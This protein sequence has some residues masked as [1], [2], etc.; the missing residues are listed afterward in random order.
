MSWTGYKPNGEVFLYECI[1]APVVIS[2]DCV[3]TLQN[4]YSITGTDG[5]GSM[6][7]LVHTG[8]LTAT[9][10]CEY[11]NPCSIW[12]TVKT[13][14]L[15]G[16]AGSQ[17]EFAFPPSACPAP[18]GPT[19]AGSGDEAANRAMFKWE[20][21]E[22]VAPASISVDY[23]Q[24][25]SPLG[26]QNFV[27][28]LV[29]Y[30]VTGDP[31]DQTQLDSLTSQG[32]TFAYAPLSAS[33]LVF[34][35]NVHD[36]ADL[37]QVTDMKLTPDLL[38]KIFTR[39]LYN[40]NIDPNLISLNP[41]APNWAPLVEPVGEA[42]ASAQTFELTSWFWA[43]AQ[44]TYEAGGTQF[45]GG[46]TD[47]YPATVGL[48]L[49]QT[50]ASAALQ[51][52][53]PT[54]NSDL[55]Q[56]GYIGWM[57]ASYAAQYGLPTVQVENAAGDFV[58][59]TPDSVAAALSHWVPN[60]DGVT[61]MPDFANTDPAQYPLPFVSF[62]VAPTSI[63]EGQFDQ[64]DGVKGDVLRT[65]LTYTSTTGQGAL[66][67]GYDPL[68]ANMVNQTAETVLLIPSAENPSPSPSP[69]P[70]PA[71]TTPPP[72]IVPPPV[73][74]PP[75]VIP[76]APLSPLPS[77]SPSPICGSPSATPSPSPS[78][79]SSPSPSPSASPS[80]SASASPSPSLSPSPVCPSVATVSVAPAAGLLSSPSA[81]LVLPVLVGIAAVGLLLGPVLQMGDPRKR[82]RLRRRARTTSPTEGDTGP[83][84]A[85]PTEG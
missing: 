22:C 56:F 85:A 36:R 29:D 71:L 62:I 14:S 9:V 39:Q 11:P 34:A 74:V 46:P 63:Y 44:A 2:T 67:P 60:A 72:V 19:V 41:D 52:A 20:S 80:A 43:V 30:A 10:D 75:V 58:T 82:F 21:D 55:T 79:S 45:Q 81:R 35:Y 13:N 53:E 26:R 3:A 16:G 84:E 54:P 49:R 24:S 32:R 47:I 5:T 78:A 68:P 33:S 65:Y 51:V 37:K 77:L 27:D 61:G 4:N 18:T 66:P 7:Y 28:G 8:A 40:W 25:N 50:M 69:S 48:D 38:A 59:A 57:D 17:I 23:T 1:A 6:Y 15:T 76:S 64:F 31:F 12:V 42:V 73:V 70:T 83:G